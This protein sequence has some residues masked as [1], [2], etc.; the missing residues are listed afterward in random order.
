[1][2][3]AR[4]SIGG[5]TAQ[6]TAEWF[7]GMPCLPLAK[8]HKC[9]WNRKYGTYTAEIH[10]LT[11]TMIENPSVYADGNDPTRGCFLLQCGG[12]VTQTI[13]NV[14]KIMREDEHASITPISVD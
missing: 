7:G 9:D 14:L 1:M 8:L 13:Y 4:K 12:R 5:M 11:E 6:E 10:I 2:Q 3:F